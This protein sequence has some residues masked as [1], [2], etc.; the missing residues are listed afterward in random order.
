V[1]LFGASVNAARWAVLGE[2]AVRV[3]NAA[4]F[5]WLLRLLDADDFGLV[6]LGMAVVSLSIL[7][8]DAGLGKALIQGQERTAQ[9]ADVVFRLNVVFGLVLYLLILVAARPLAAVTA[10]DRLPQLLALMALQ[11]PLGALGTVQAALLQ[12]QLDFAGVFRARALGALTNCLVA[13]ASAWSGEGHLSLVYGVLAGEVVQTSMLWSRS[14]W[15]PR[16]TLGGRPDFKLIRF[17]AWILATDLLGWFFVWADSLLLG[18][19]LQTHDVG[20]YRTGGLFVSYLFSILVA[21]AIPVALSALSRLQN[22]RERFLEALLQVNRLITF[23]ALPLAAVIFCVAPLVESAVFGAEW[24]GVYRVVGW[25]GIT[26]GI[27]WLVGASSEAYKAAG[28]PHLEAAALAIAA[29]IYLPCYLAV[30]ASTSDLTAFVRCRAL[31]GLVGVAIHVVLLQRWLG[32][33]PT[34]FLK[35]A[36]RPALATLALLAAHALMSTI[37]PPTTAWRT[38]QALVALAVGA[39]AVLAL[40]RQL[41]V[42]VLQAA[43]GTRGRT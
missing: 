25:M 8:R 28:R 4:I 9:S 26:S 7:L 19:F 41:F 15:R 34:R 10:E 30:L 20:L 31:L 6:T 16:L 35:N 2:L 5:L 33:S 27:G 38:L 21:P 42:R 22:E 39:A 11:L 36:A 13:L 14:G 37:A 12:K 40:D 24:S 32:L 29:A 17:S 43:I 3:S 18:I 23:I 1:T